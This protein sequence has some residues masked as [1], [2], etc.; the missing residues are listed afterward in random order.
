MFS[1]FSKPKLAKEPEPVPATAPAPVSAQLPASGSDDDNNNNN[2]SVLSP[3]GSSPLLSRRSMNQLGFFFAGAGF[4]A[5]STLITHRSITR[6]QIAALPKFYQ[7]SHRSPAAR[8]KNPEGSMI[9][10]EALNLA[11]LNVIAFGIMAAGGV[12]WAF[13]IS[14]IDDLRAMARRNIGPPGG[15]TDEEA[16]REVEEW[17]AKVLS[18]KMTDSKDG[19]GKTQ[20]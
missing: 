9:A 7:P 13:D 20:S 2:D 19:D 11:T 12:S 14:S 17:M 5:F 10:V 18:R 1:F 8:D 3:T 15:R 6:K 16:E 4:L